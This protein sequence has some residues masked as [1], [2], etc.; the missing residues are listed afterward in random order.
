MKFLFFFIFLL[1]EIFNLLF[2]AAVK[3]ANVYGFMLG[4][5]NSVI[6]YAIASAFQLGKD[7]F[8]MRIFS[9]LSLA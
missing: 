8:I 1:L 5:T 9:K 7:K 3:S 2:R 4:F 6:Y